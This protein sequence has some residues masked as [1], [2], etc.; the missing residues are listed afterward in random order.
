[1]HVT[2]QY[3]VTGVTSVLRISPDETAGSLKE[4]ILQSAGGGHA[5][6]TTLSVGGEDVV[7]LATPIAHTALEEGGRV[8]LRRAE[9]EVLAPHS[10]DFDMCSAVCLSPCG[11]RMAVGH[12][13]DAISMWDTERAAL[14]W[15]ACDEDGNTAAFVV[16][17]CFSP[18]ANLIAAHS[19]PSVTLR[20][21][22]DGVKIMDLKGHTSY[23]TSLCFSPCGATLISGS[24]DATVKVWD[25]DEAVC[26]ESVTLSSKVK[27]VAMSG[28]TL[29]MSCLTKV[30]VWDVR[31]GV[32]VWEIPVEGL[33]TVVLH[34]DV[35]YVRCRAEL[36]TY[37]LLTQERLKRH[38]NVSVADDGS[39]GSL[40]LYINDTG[41]TFQSFSA[42]EK[43]C[44]LAGIKPPNEIAITP[45]GSY[46]VYL[47]DSGEEG[48]TLEFRAIEF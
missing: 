35:L 41:E 15:E 33:S 17:L 30:V 19:G 25:I 38:V 5:F 14:L 9:A 18:S 1:M 32:A 23:I 6:A 3:S 34:D 8:S 4:K 16:A 10:Y 13:D 40:S 47:E 29:V 26:T 31:V 11:T 46:V 22:I 21:S 7:D 27:T 2:S 45:C 36:S 39:L 44:W 24:N 28:D 20:R 42:E 12:T 48:E 37:S 43:R